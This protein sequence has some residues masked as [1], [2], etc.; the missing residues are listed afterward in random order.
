[1][2]VAMG[3]EVLLALGRTLWLSTNEVGAAAMMMPRLIISELAA[4]E[5]PVD[6]GEDS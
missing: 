4:A 2:I 6:N 5:P 3:A 1:M